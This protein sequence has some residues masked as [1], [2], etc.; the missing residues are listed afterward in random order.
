MAATA[1]NI[2]KTIQIRSSFL[3]HSCESPTL[4]IG[5]V[6]VKD[7]VNAK[8]ANFSVATNHC[9]TAKDG[10]H[11]IDTTWFRV[12]AWESDTIKNL[13]QLQKGVLSMSSVASGCRDTLQL[14]ERRE[15]SSKSSPVKSS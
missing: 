3:F 13:D 8:V 6:Y 1:A 2:T 12:L 10:C 15:A 11:V 9:D 4:I 7:F 5:S 14:M